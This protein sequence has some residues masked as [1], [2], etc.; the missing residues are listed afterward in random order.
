M[1]YNKLGNTDLIVSE[2]GFGVLT[3]GHNQLELPIEQGA[4]VVRYA[5][6]NGINFLD[7]AEYYETYPYIKE[8]LKG[9][10][11]RPII[12]SKSLG[13]TR[14]S[15]ER[16]I[17]NGL[18]ELGID[19]F[20]IFL[21]HEVRHDG[22]FK[23][24]IG[25]FE[26]LKDAKKNGKVKYIGLSTH[27]VDVTRAAASIEELDIV[28]PLVNIA[29]LGI[30]DGEN[31]GTRE[32]MEAAI[33]LN[34]KAGKGIFLMK[35]FGGGNLVGRYQEALNYGKSIEGVSSMMI[36]FGTTEEVDKALAYSNGT[37]PTGYVPDLTNK[38]ITIEQG[39]CEHCY[40]CMRK[41]PNN[42][43]YEDSYGSIRVDNDV[44]LTCGYCA[45]VCPTRALIFIG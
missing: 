3:V 12:C 21:L 40:A 39:D 19:Y 30:R 23:N 15:M 41:C 38:R 33:S 25:A 29:G 8:A 31:P 4:T 35:I 37:L 6:D 42:A 28:F 5:L 7:T 26:A 14:S 44:C 22:D 18:E 24:R 43:I 9:L 27:H 13:S 1:K 45:P 36:G 16:A 2:I 34:V 32:D 10:D 20:D 11:K 17:D